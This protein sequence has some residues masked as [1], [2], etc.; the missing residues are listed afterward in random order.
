MFRKKRGI[1]EKVDEKYEE[2]KC[3]VNENEKGS[4][5]LGTHR[6][7][8]R[9]S[10]EFTTVYKSISDIEEVLQKGGDIVMVTR[11]Y[12]RMS[13]MMKNAERY[14]NKKRFEV[15]QCK[16]KCLVK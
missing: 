3:K 5:W 4:G 9:V 16:T 7:Q 15:N 6:G 2:I 14:M 10:F 1:V 12:R 13:E 11:G 8:T